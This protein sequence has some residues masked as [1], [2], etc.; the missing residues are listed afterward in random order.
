MPRSLPAQVDVGIVEGAVSSEDDLHK[1]RDF[2][3]HCKILISLGDC[4][5]TS[6]VPAMR[7]R[8]RSKEVMDRLH[9]ERHHDPVIP[10][11]RSSRP[12]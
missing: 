3:A 10:G 12:C 11:A 4:A 6:N 9:R 5:I 7:N 1:I 8:S 2:R